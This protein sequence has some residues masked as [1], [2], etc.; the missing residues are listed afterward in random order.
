MADSS[1]SA[2]LTPRLRGAGPIPAEPGPPFPTPAP[3]PLPIPR[4]NGVASPTTAT[5]STFG[6]LLVDDNHHHRIPLVPALRMRGYRVLHAAG[7]ESAEA[8]CRTTRHPIHILVAREEMKR[9]DGADLARRLKLERPDI[10]ILLMRS[11]HFGR[12]L[13]TEEPT[14]SIEKPDSALIQDPFTPA[15][16]CERVSGLLASSESCNEKTVHVIE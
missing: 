10:Q 8:I 12:G 13:T 1:D 2:Q 11:R 16:L 9:M 4:V 6:V 5:S 3:L 7:A 14:A 15:E